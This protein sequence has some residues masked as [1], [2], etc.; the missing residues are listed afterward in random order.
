VRFLILLC[1][2]SSFACSKPV[3][4]TVG[5]SGAGEPCDLTQVCAEGLNCRGGLCTP[6][7][8][9]AGA[10]LDSGPQTDD[11]GEPA[12]AALPPT[13]AGIRRNVN[14]T[15]TSPGR[16]SSIEAGERVDAV[17]E[18]RGEN[19]SDYRL[20]WSSDLAGEIG[21]DQVPVTGRVL[22]SILLA[23]NGIHRLLVE[24]LWED[25][26]LAS[27][28][29]LV[30]VCGW[31]VLADFEG[32]MPGW[33]LYGHANRDQRGWLELTG[34]QQARKG[35]VYQTSHRIEPGDV[36]L[37]FRI[38]TGHCDEPGPCRF[39]QTQAADGFSM[40]IWDVTNEQELANLFDNARPGG[41]MGY[42]VAGAYGDF[43]GD[44]F[45]V[46]FDTWYND[47]DGNGSHTDPTRQ[48]HLDVTLDGD[49]GNSV[50]FAEIANLEDNEW[51]EVELII[52]GN[53]L[54]VNLDAL[55]VIDE[56]VDGLDFKGGYIGFSGTTGYYTNFH[57][58][59][60][61]RTRPACT[62]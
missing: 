53:H 11:A 44:A 26:V 19:L 47:G 34:N 35:A 60:D 20:R 12:D 10:L 48:N 61:L 33:Q 49:P 25:E 22:R 54:R 28:E 57:R 1:V 7:R 14:L 2:F 13:D 56:R 3:P 62:P 21:F 51:H 6:P 30:G 23:E 32:G 5:F 37:A 18:L 52:D 29:V 38:S 31:E 46:E 27:D 42:G 43:S 15:L 40:N 24:L 39:D 45:H 50:A 9:D 59:D 4:T 41:G 36:R 55:P 17:V 58:F 8:P 16:R